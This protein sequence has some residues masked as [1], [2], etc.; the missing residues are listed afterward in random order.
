MIQNRATIRELNQTA[1]RLCL[2]EYGR[3]R[4]ELL[5]DL[6]RMQAAGA[7]PEEMRSMLAAA[8]ARQAPARVPDDA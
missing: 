3:I 7:T 5:A 8:R 1:H 2:A 6:E 4:S